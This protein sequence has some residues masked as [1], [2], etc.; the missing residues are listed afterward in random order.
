MDMPPSNC[1]LLLYLLDLLATFA[2]HTASNLMSIQGSSLFCFLFFVCFVCFFALASVVGRKVL[3]IFNTDLV[4]VF[5]P[6]LLV[7]SDR[8]WWKGEEERCRDVLEFMTKQLKALL[9]AR[10]TPEEL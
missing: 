4:G 7:H 5:Q 6:A 3:T 8:S 9:D 2:Q 1:E 10:S